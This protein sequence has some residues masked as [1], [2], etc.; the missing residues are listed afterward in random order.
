[1]GISDAFP[2][3]RER[4]PGREADHSPLSNTEMKNTWKFISIP[5]IYLHSVWDNFTFNLLAIDF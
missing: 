3:T 2:R 5:T 1:M 4:R